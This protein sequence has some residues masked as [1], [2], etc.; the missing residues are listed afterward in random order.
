LGQGRTKKAPSYNKPKV[1]KI[2]KESIG[3]GG[4]IK[5]ELIRTRKPLTSSRGYGDNFGTK[6]GVMK[7]KSEFAS[8]K[9]AKKS[10]HESGT[11]LQPNFISLTSGLVLK[12]VAGP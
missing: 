10:L 1:S 4:V 2:L 11:P 5:R 6:R 7:S 12:D 9:L 3:R 8:I